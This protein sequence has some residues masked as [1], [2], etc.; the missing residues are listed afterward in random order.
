MI[1]LNNKK[2]LISGVG[3]G[4]GKAMLFHCLK[5]GAFVVGFTKSQKD[6]NDIKKKNLTNLILLK[7]DVSDQKFINYLFKYLRK[8][9]IKLNGLINNAGIRQRKSFLKISEKDLY[10]ILK[11][12]FFSVFRISQKFIN[13]IDKK[14]NSSIVNI[15]SIVGPNGFSELTGYASTKSALN[16]LT[17]SLSTE[18]KS[19]NYKVRVNCINPGFTKSSYFK[20]FKKKRKLYSWTLKNI[21]VKRWGEPEEI[22]ELASFL[23]SDNSYNISGQCINIDGG[24]TK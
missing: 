10:E 16:G 23:L 5:Q 2:I 21:P 17:K 8:R 6:I 22:S 20:N 14:I 9:N 18:L 19:K 4:I 7:G 15:G 13:Q 12:N 11:I 1:I 3:K 24:W